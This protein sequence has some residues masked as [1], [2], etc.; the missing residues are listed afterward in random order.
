MTGHEN[1]V[2]PTSIAYLGFNNLL[3]RRLRAI[4]ARAK[5]SALYRRF[6]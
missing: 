6:Q 4:P 5:G 3:F 1:L 2:V